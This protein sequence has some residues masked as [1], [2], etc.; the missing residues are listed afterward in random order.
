MTLN[1]VAVDINIIRL[2]CDVSER[3]NIAFISI[4][5]ILDEEEATNLKT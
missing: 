3:E 2:S 5:H 1:L 4:Y